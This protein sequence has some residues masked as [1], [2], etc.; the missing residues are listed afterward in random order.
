MGQQESMNC[1]DATAEGATTDNP[2]P[3]PKVLRLEVFS[4][5]SPMEAR[6]RAFILAQELIPRSRLLQGRWPPS[7]VSNSWRG[8]QLWAAG[9]GATLTADGAASA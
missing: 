7:D 1:D 9:R 3:Y 8:T 2:T 4:K 6:S 5:S